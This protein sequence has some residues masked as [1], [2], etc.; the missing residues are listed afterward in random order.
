MGIS[1]SSSVSI[2]SSAARTPRP[3]TNN[4]GDTVTLAESEQVYQLYHQGTAS[5]SDRYQS[6]LAS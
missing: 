3:T 2:A 4:S 5:V 6:Q 1:L